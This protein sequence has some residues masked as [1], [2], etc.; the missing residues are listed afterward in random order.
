M[1]RSRSLKL[2]RSAPGQ[3]LSRF[4][5]PAKYYVRQRS[6]LVGL[7][8]EVP[9]QPVSMLKRQPA[10]PPSPK[11]ATFGF[12][13]PWRSPPQSSFAL[14]LPPEPFGP[15]LAYP[16]FRPSSRH[17]RGAATS[18]R[19]MPLPPRFVSVH[20]LSQPLDGLLRPPALQ[21]C[22]IPQPRPGLSPFRGFS[23]RAAVRSH[24]P[25]VPPCR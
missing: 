18:V 19:R 13:L 6:R 11:R 24:R 2:P 5:P 9:L 15:G 3:P 7:P 14:F 10:L 8:R 1:S 23:P 17:H 21:A 25:S 16:R 12:I 20:R 4:E 22:F